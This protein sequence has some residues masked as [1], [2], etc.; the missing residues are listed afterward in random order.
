MHTSLTQIVDPSNEEIKEE[1]KAQEHIANFFNLENLEN[2]DI[3]TDSTTMSELD[4]IN[5]PDAISYNPKFFEAAREF[6]TVVDVRAG[7]P[8]KGRAFI[9][10]LQSSFINVQNAAKPEMEQLNADMECLNEV[11]PQ[12]TVKRST[13]FTLFADELIKRITEQK[14]LER[15]TSTFKVEEVY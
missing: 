11:N 1:L 7:V 3:N 12:R 5:P 6:I 10:Y 8:R 4:E 15:L 14:T 13:K 9:E 2:E